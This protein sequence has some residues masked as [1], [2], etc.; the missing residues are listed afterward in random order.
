MPP[1]AR[2]NVVQSK[3]PIVDPPIVYFL[4]ISKE[5]QTIQSESVVPESFKTTEYSDILKEES[6]QQQFDETIIQDIVSKI[7]NQTDYPSGTACF[8]CCHPF[9][10]KSFVVPTHYDAH[11]NQYNAEGHY[12]SAECAL[13]WIYADARLT[14]TQRWLRHSLLAS[15]YKIT[16]LN[17]APDKRALRMF[18]GTLSIEQYRRYI[19]EGGAPLQ[20]AMPPIRLYMP[21]INTHTSS[22]DIKSYVT[23]SNDTVD[24]ASQQL[25]L[26]RSKPVHQTVH[27]LDKCMG[28]N[29]A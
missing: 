22:R 25:R 14:D 21:S 27:T 20:L 28:L 23:L 26:K 9:A 13:G 15:M 19:R 7:H 3:E 11:S 5:A 12:C 1:R 10:W 29:T 18:G 16:T 2:K 4:K 24:K 6:V 17:R 8:W